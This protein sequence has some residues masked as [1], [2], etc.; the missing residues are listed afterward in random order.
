MPRP[1]YPVPVP[2]QQPPT[3]S[4]TRFYFLR[5]GCNSTRYCSSYALLK[6]TPRLSADYSTISALVGATGGAVCRCA[7]GDEEGQIRQRGCPSPYRSSPFAHGTI[8]LLTF[9]TAHWNRPLFLN[10]ATHNYLLAATVAWFGP[11]PFIRVH[12]CLQSR[13]VF[14]SVSRTSY[15][16]N[17][18][19]LNINL[20][21]TSIRDDTCQ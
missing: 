10:T 19:T 3:R 11:T 6:T 12:A 21:R 15:F 9:L 4:G 13:R 7:L 20:S 2:P 17:R 8:L 18:Y 14:F 1:G 16:P 5:P